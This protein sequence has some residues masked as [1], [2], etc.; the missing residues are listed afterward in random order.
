MTGREIKFKPATFY[1]GIADMLAGEVDGVPAQNETSRD[2]NESPK[3]QSSDTTD[4]DH[5][6]P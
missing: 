4:H 5:N 3:P 6:E 1:L 2:R